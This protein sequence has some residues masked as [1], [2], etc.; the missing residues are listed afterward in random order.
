MQYRITAADGVDYAALWLETQGLSE[1][2]ALEYFAEHLSY[3]CR[4]AY[5]ARAN[6]P[7]V[8]LG[9]HQGSFEYVFDH[10]TS[11]ESSGVVPYSSSEESRLVVAC[12]RS[13]PRPRARDDFR[14]RGWV[15][16]TQRMF[17]TRW[18]KGHYIAHSLGGAV[19]GIEANVFVQH[20][21]AESDF[22]HQRKVLCWLRLPAPP[23]VPCMS[24]Q[25]AVPPSVRAERLPGQPRKILEE[26]QRL[27]TELRL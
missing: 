24:D 9:V 18:D 6:R 8:V 2:E 15:G 22:P 21:M 7:T 10:Y 26:L 12:G 13:T 3:V 17:G 16:P 19:D 5:V 14:L 23:I 11:L 20:P 27:Y 4:D 1:T 25:R